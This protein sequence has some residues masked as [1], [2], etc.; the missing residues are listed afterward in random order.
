MK[1]LNKRKKTFNYDKIT[2]KRLL[3]LIFVVVFLFLIIGFRLYKVMVIDNTKYDEILGDLT[4]TK[5]L[6]SSAPRGRILDRNY[7]VIVDNKAINSIVYKKDKNTSTKEMIEL[8]YKVSPYLDLSYSKLTKRAK[9]EFYF[10]KYPDKCDKLVTE[11]EKKKVLE[12]KMTSRELEELKINRISDDELNKFTKEDLH[13]AYLFY[14]M[15]KGY[16]YEEKVIKS[17]A[18]DKEFAYISENNTNLDGFNTKVDWERVYPYGDTLKSILGTVSTSTQGVPAELKDE[19]LEKG[20]ALND[21]VGLSYLEKQYEDYLRGEKAEYEMVNSHELKLVKEG[22]RGNDIVL[23]I[24]INLQREIEDI[25]MNQI[26]WAKSEANT[27]Y[28]DHSSVIIQDPR[29]GEIL[30]MASKRLVNGKMKDNVVSLLTSPVTPGSVVKGASMLVGYNTGAVKI[31]ETMLDQCV[32]IAGAKEKCSSVSTLGVIDDI[33][34]LAKSSNVYQFKAAIRVNGQEYFHGMRMNFNQKAFDTYRNMYRSFGLGTSTGIDLPVESLG[35][36]SKD[37]NA[38]NL[39]DFVMGQYETY[40]PVQLSQYISTIA[41]G[42]SRLQVHLLKEVR[43]SSETSELGDVIHKYEKNVMNKIN[44]SSQ[45]MSRVQEGFKAVM[46]SYG[47]YG[48]G[49]MEPWIDSAGKTGTSQSFIDTD[50]N[51]V[52]D[53]ETI[54]SLYLGYFPTYAPKVSIAVVSPNS[55]H[56]NGNYNFASLVTM[57]ITKEVTNKYIQYYGAW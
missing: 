6:G 3:V 29:T 20:Y 55:S 53:T 45:Y 22:K 14:L 25:I 40:T 32:K 24:D 50:G 9:R 26:W 54:S 28:Y 35:Y 41:N 38:G 12:R 23:S 33:T 31:G 10:Y 57:R 37:K 51:G 17:E 30:A 16:A 47:G 5:V 21:R 56:L 42:G 19:Y 39:L 46:Q 13:A 18:N 8:A 43:E 1:K 11:K 15:N 49:Y 2:N 27:E 7:N 36:T 52:I 4:Y 34:A 44:T 48:R